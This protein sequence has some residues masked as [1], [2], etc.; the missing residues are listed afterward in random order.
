MTPR[1]VTQ[2]VL[3]ITFMVLGAYDLWAFYRWGRPYTLSVVIYESARANPIV[4]FGL[5][6]LIGHLF[7][8]VKE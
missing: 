2:V 4:A 8:P 3:L 6:V 7:W 1:Q 5:G